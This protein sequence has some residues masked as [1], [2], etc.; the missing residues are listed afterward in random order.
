[1]SSATIKIVWLRLQ[2]VEFGVIQSGATTLYVDNTSTIQ[3]ASNLVFHERMKHNEVDCHFIRHVKS[4]N[5]CAA[6]LY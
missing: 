6:H 3:I 1:M 5:I 4:K 2:L